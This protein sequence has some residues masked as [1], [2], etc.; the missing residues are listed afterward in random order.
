MKEEIKELKK[1]IDININVCIL[2]FWDVYMYDSK[3]D[4]LF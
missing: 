1:I 4:L 3:I 2:W